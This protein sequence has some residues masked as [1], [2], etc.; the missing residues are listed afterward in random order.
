MGKNPV[1]FTLGKSAKGGDSRWYDGVITTTLRSVAIGQPLIC[2]N[3]EILPASRVHDASASGQLQSHHHVSVC[4]SPT[5]CLPWL[6]DVSLRTGMLSWEC[7]FYMGIVKEHD[8]IGMGF[9]QPP[10]KKALCV[11]R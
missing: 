6:P 8:S 4:A 11:A 7:V 3:T 2:G 5:G 1:G 10:R 9:P